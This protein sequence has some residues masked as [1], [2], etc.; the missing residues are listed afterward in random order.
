MFHQILDTFQKEIHNA[1]NEDKS[2][3]LEPTMIAFFGSESNAKAVISKLKADYTNEQDFNNALEKEL[4]LDSI[5]KLQSVLMSINTLTQMID[6]DKEITNG[7]FHPF[8]K[9]PIKDLDFVNLFSSK[10]YFISNVLCKQHF[11]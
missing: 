1:T 6:F 3:F 7:N 11:K 5:E 2:K 8:N 9:I 4:H 10:F